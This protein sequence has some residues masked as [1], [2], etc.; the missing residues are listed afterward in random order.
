MILESK[1]YYES[2]WYYKFNVGEFW[3]IGGKD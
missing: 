2:D 1:S 3:E